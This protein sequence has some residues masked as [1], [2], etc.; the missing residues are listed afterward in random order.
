MQRIRDILEPE[1][2]AL[3]VLRGRLVVGSDRRAPLGGERAA[4][5]QRLQQSGADAPHARAGEEVGQPERLPA[6]ASRQR[7][8]R[9]EVGGCDAD[10]GA[11]LMQER[12]GSENVRALPRE[13]GGQAHRN[14]LRQREAGELELRQSRVAGQASGKHCKLVPGAGEIALEH[15]QRGFRLCKL[16]LLGEDVGA[17]NGPQLKL[18]LDN[19]ELAFLRGDDLVGRANLGAHRRL[20]HRRGHDIRRQRQMRAFELVLLK[21]DERLESLDLA[22]FAAEHVE[23]VRDTDV[24]VIKREQAGTDA[25]H[26]ERRA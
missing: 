18:A 19:L 1:Q 21:I 4:M 6:E 16:R 8:L 14:F 13:R 9:I 11:R 24:R 23:Q 22:P 15:G 2:H 20:V 3:P 25:G 7:D 10:I 12:L 26:P 17:R 5:K